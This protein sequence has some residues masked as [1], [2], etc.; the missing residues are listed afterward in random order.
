M[1]ASCII[2][3]CNHKR[4]EFGKLHA[5]LGPM[6]V[7]GTCQWCGERYFAGTTWRNFRFALTWF[8]VKVTLWPTGAHL[9]P[10]TNFSFSL[11]YSLD[12]CGIVI[13]YHPLMRGRVCNLL[14]NCFWALPEQY[15][16]GQSP[17]ELTALFYCLIWD[18]VQ[19]L[20][21]LAR[22]VTLRSKSR[23]SHGLILLSHLRLHQP[24]GP[25]PRISKSR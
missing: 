1:L 22:A 19:F 25:G 16:L 6:C 21:G 10:A 20:L 8:K 4:M 23:R 12:S 18:S 2:L 7:F 15:L 14:Y 13:L 17:A 5:Y 9:G 24:E 3:L 11:K